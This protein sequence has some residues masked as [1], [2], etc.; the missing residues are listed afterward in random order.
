MQRFWM[1]IRLNGLSQT[2][3]GKGSTLAVHFLQHRFTSS[4]SLEFHF[5]HCRRF[6]PFCCLGSRRQNTIGWGSSVVSIPMTGS[7]AW[8]RCR[9]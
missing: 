6:L 7:R 3:E 5:T 1:S 4:L 2:S 9:F 8:C